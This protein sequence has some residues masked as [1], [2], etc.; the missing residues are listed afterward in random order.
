[1]EILIRVCEVG[2]MCVSDVKKK[3]KEKPAWLNLKWDS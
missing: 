1:M 2:Y 3:K